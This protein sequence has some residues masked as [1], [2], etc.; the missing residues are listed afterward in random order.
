MLYRM[1]NP[2][3]W[4]EN[5]PLTLEETMADAKLKARRHTASSNATIWSKRRTNSPRAWYCLIVIIVLAGAVA[6]ATAPRRREKSQEVRNIQYVNRVTKIPAMNDSASV[7]RKIS[8]PVLRSS[9]SLKYFPTP[10]AIHANAISLTKSMWMTNCEVINP[11]T[12][13]PINIPTRI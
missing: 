3:A 12:S 2:I 8:L 10:N 5:A 9:Y 7:I 4:I 11:S 13:G 6:V 1:G